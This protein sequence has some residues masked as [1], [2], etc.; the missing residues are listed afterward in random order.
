VT[1]PDLGFE[2]WLLNRT[3]AFRFGLD[4]TSPTVG[5]T[6]KFAPFNLDFVYVRNMAK[7]RSELFGS[8]SNSVIA[9]LSVDYGALFKR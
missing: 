3:F 7:A 6:Y 9:T 2:Q 4:E 1:H 5:F 8:E